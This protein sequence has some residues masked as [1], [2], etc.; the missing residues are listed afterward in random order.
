MKTPICILA[1]LFVAPVYAEFD[2]FGSAGAKWLTEISEQK[3]YQLEFAYGELPHD[4]PQSTN[5]NREITEEFLKA[6][7]RVLIAASAND[8]GKIEKEDGTVIYY[9]TKEEGGDIRLSFSVTTRLSGV[10][11]LN[12][13]I[14]LP[15][16]RWIALGGL[17]SQKI[18]KADQSVSSETSYFILAIRIKK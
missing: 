3:P 17:T 14:S 13:E 18:T 16:D 11:E 12:S 8:L 10:S 5:G 7:R 6:S 9:R 1:L 4:L 15:I 2:P